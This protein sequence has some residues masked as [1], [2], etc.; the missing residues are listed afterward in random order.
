MGLLIQVGI[1]DIKGGTAGRDQ[2]WDREYINRGRK[3]GRKEGRKKLRMRGIRKEE[4]KK[5]RKK[6]IETEVNVK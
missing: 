3:E 4:R 6:E 5:G 1:M 2:S